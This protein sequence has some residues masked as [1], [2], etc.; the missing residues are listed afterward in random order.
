MK[1]LVIDDDPDVVEVVSLTFEM[2]WPDSTIV[3]ALDGASGIEMVDSENPSLVILD[4]GLPD[5]DGYT[6]C[7]EIRRF[8][9]VPI[10]M[11]TVREKEADIVKGLQLGADDYVGKPFRAIEFMARV[12]SVLRRA[13]SSPYAVGEEKPFQH[14]TLLVD[15]TKHE[16]FL[17]DRQV[18]LTPTEYQLLYH[19][20]KNAG[21][22]LT[23]RM[24]LGRVWGREYLDETNYLKVHI[25]HLRQKLEDDPS[26]PRYIL[27]ERTVGYKFAK[28]E[29]APQR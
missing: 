6:V 4:I 16:V 27:T 8:S 24:L 23:H 18:R 13:Q 3:S 10:I 2:R 15:F 7:Q 25:K 5:M 22:V 11:L 12:Q 17:G 19:L 14:S 1:V 21:K 28:A 20:T 9:D 29:A 26:E